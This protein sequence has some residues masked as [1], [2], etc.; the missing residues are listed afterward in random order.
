MKICI[1]GLGYIGLPTAALF[2]THGH[3]VVGIDINKNIVESINEGITP[4]DEP[5]LPELLEK[6]V[7]SKNLVAKTE[8][9]DSDV[10]LI[11]VPT[12]LDKEMKMAELK[13]VR[14]AAEMIYPHLRKENL[15]IL[16]STVPPG[17]CEKLLVPILKKSGLKVSKDF[18][19][20]HCPER[21][22]PG[23]TIYEMVH[24]D[25]IIGGIDKK[26]TALAKSL[27]SCFVKGIFY[28][29]NT[30]TA[31]F[32]K[33]MENTFRDINIALANEF[34]QIA[35]ECGVNVWEAIELANRHPRVNILKPGPGVGGHCI[36]IDPWFLT[37]NSTR[38]RI[39]SL[40]REI[41]DGMPNH[42]LQIVKG[43]LKGV[44]NPVITVLGV[45]YKGGVDDT[46]ET[47]ALKFIKFAE[48]EGYKVKVHDPYVKEFEY[49][50]LELEEAVKDSDC[51]LLLTDHPEFKEIDPAKIS[52]LMR[53]RNLVDTRN[54]LDHK[55]WKEA[56]FKTKILGDGMH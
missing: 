37:E 2:A 51:I 42:V 40:A 33:L 26:S 46:R 45:A 47:P 49:E 13:Y 48:N 34:A 10:F 16:E 56:G 19:L 36:A 9:E 15:V 52:R 43:M 1:L 7:T 23:N 54:I 18:Y 17:T 11:A 31:E 12:P 27:Y 30:I 8:V 38:C 55:S 29:T 21:A 5:G 22:I 41:N 50:V 24:N 20:A 39:V 28:L 4:F 6:A 25:R 14:S 44:D 53:N 32:V 35:E 3:E